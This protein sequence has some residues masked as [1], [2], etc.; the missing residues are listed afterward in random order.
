LRPAD[1]ADP[2]AHDRCWLPGTVQG[3]APP[4]VIDL[5]P[6]YL[7]P[8]LLPVGLLRDAYGSA[9]QEFGSASLAYGDNRGA[10]PLRSEL[11]ASE[12]AGRRAPCTPEQLVIT[13]GTSQMLHLLA[14]T[15]ARPGATV[16]V[17]EVSYDLGRRV[18]VDCGLRL[19]EVPGDRA[20]MDPAALRDALR[21]H[22]DVAFIYLNP[23][24]HN[25][26][27]TVVPLG[28][29]LELL[30]VARE[31]EALIVEDD[32]YAGLALDEP[33][34]PDSLAELSGF[35]GVIRLLT[36]S[37][38]LAP[39]L[40]LGWLQ[41]DHA[42]TERLAG[43]GVLSSGGALNHTTSLAVLML[44]RSGAYGRHVDW[45]RDRLRERRD[46]LVAALRGSLPGDR[47]RFAVPGG[48]FFVWLRC[49]TG[50][51]EKELL[52]TAARAGVWV[53]GGSRFGTTGEP[54]IRLSYSLNGPAELTHAAHRLAAALTA[55]G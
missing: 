53:A 33:G 22:G 49:G 42:V 4:G 54:S 47:F 37:K 2:L 20:G 7:D 17:D 10:W 40:R 18:F 13:A 5:G 55:A 43:C 26:T 50:E 30:A 14:V 16:M 27:G 41:A 28:R 35:L 31:H 8:L 36:F 34:P 29:R 9:L 52:A 48:G 15:F 1:T 12:L 6:G 3:V 38:T 19:R 44:L 25:P 24:F 23:S 46:A 45:L 32:A 51:T 39:G 21:A 11:A